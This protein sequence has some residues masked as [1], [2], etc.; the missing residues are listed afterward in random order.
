MLELLE[1]VERRVE[2]G[3]GHHWPVV[4]QEQRVADSRSVLGRGRGSWVARGEV[5]QQLQAPD[6][7]AVVGRQRRKRLLGIQPVET[8]QGRRVERVRVYDGIGIGASAQHRE[9]EERLL[10]RPR[11]AEVIPGRVEH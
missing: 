8:R 10:G 11:T 4:T 6:P 5:G 9:V 7:H 2:I 1:R 3:A